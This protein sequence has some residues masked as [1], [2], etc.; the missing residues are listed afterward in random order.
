[1]QVK[2]FVAPTMRQALTKVREAL[3]PDAVILSN[4]RVENGVELM[5]TVEDVEYSDDLVKDT[6]ALK[7]RLYL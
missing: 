2:R 1:M 6:Y 5:T 3:G 4:R 7:R